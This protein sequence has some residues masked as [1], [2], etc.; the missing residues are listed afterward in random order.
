[1]WFLVHASRLVPPLYDQRAPQFLVR[2]CC[3][4]RALLEQLACESCTLVSIGIRGLLACTYEIK[5]LACKDTGLDIKREMKRFYLSSD[6]CWSPHGQNLNT[7]HINFPPLKL[8]SPQGSSST[9]QSLTRTA[10]QSFTPR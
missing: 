7:W 8:E 4:T 1:M 5:S 2:S 3:K 6:L 10:P 9:N